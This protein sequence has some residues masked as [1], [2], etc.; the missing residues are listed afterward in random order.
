MFRPVFSLFRRMKAAKLF[1]KPPSPREALVVAHRAAQD[2]C[3]K[4]REAYF[5]CC[6]KG[7]D[8]GAGERWLPYHQAKSRVL[9]IER[10][11]RALA[12]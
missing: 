8:R 1:A 10:E 2:E 5:R 12:L 4:A 3:E 11:L 9:R 6:D 7:D